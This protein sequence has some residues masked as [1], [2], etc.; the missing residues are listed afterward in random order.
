MGLLVLAGLNGLG[1]DRLDLDAAYRNFQDLN[2]CHHQSRAS[3]SPKPQCFQ[4]VDF[5]AQDFAFSLKH[6]PDAGAFLRPVG[7][8]DLNDIRVENPEF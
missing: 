8:K 5:A 4:G 6:L 3:V 1:R 2:I 7:L